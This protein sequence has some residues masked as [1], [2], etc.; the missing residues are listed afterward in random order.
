MP[1]KGIVVEISESVKLALSRQLDLAKTEVAPGVDRYRNLSTFGFA[2]LIESDSIVADD[3]RTYASGTQ[4]IF[5]SP[6]TPVGTAG[7]AY[8]VM[9]T[10]NSEVFV[11]FP[12]SNNWK[13]KLNGETIQPDIALDWGTRFSPQQTGLIE[14][15]Y[16]TDGKHKLLMLLQSLLWLVAFFGLIRSL[17]TARRVKQ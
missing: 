1:S 7:K 4:Q 15:N 10:S 12:Y 16:R 6:L 11:A 3:F 5:T 14:L 2:S 13:A 9:A 17:A 8:Q